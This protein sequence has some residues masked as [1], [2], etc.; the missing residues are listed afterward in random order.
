MKKERI[1]MNKLKLKRMERGLMQEDMARQL[2]ISIHI[3]KRIEEGRQ[4]PK[5]KLA[6][7]ISR[8]LRCNI[9][10]II[11]VEWYYEIIN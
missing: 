7:Q 10:E 6:F 1:P 9:E 8:V 4:Q 11:P 3:Y 5:L 2:A